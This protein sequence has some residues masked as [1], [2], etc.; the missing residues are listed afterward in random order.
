MVQQ[1]SSCTYFL[2]YNVFGMSVVLRAATRSVWSTMV[3]ADICQQ[4]QEQVAQAIERGPLWAPGETVIVAVSGGA[5]SLCLLHVLHA[6]QPRHGG[7]LHVA[8]LDHRFRGAESAAEAARVSALAAEWGLPATVGAVDVPALMARERLS[9]EEAA[10]RARYRFL[11]GVAAAAEATAI[12]LGHT[13]DDQAETV[14]MHILR[15]T[16]MAGLRGMRP[17]S[18][19]APGMC[20]GLALARPLW[21]VRPLLAL[22]RAETATY[23]AACGL[24]PAQDAW[25]QDRRFLRVRLRQE[26]LPLLETINPRVR[27]ALLRLAEL[28]AWQD[29]GL[30]RLLDERWPALATVDGGTVCLDLAAWRGLPMA[31]RLQALRRAL[32][33]VRGHQEDLT[34]EAAVAAA[35]LDGLG[36]GG[37][38]ALAEDVV[39]R[40]AYG[41]I[42]VGRRADLLGTSVWP[43]LVTGC[44]PLDV[45]GRTELPGGY[46]L[47]AEVLSPRQAECGAAGLREAYLDA[48]AC[49]PRLWL[50]ARR[51]GD[52]FRPLGLAGWKKLQDFF[53]DEKVPRAERDR[54]PLIVSPRGIVWVVGY[55]LDERFR[56]R[57]ETRQVLHLAWEAPRVADPG[58]L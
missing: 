33:R 4:V 43:D 2:C 24:T 17:R 56:V 25:N 36:V 7:R 26:V 44:I 20:A 37:E 50:R 27:A 39:A 10:R 38:V 45:P 49:G 48:D 41:A 12:A 55:R 1:Q 23:C 35:R 6:L 5:D 31:L 51:P 32:G 18:P 22:T 54:V 13:A 14:L 47:L 52:R 3:Q 9:A 11:A 30:E 46:A 19:L 42:A 29:E 57:P 16:G 15:G 40:R 58:Q 21:L 8:H 34:W 28:A 53:V